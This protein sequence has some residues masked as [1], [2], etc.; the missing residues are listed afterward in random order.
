M[1]I[2]RREVGAGH[3]VYV[4]AEVGV[5]HDG[6]VGRAL[7][8]VDVA[9]EAGADAVKVQYFETDRLMS[10]EAK[11]AAY[12]RAAGETDPVSMLRRLELPIDALGAIAERAWS[13]GL[14]AIVTVFS[15]E[16][17]E[18]AMRV[19]WDAYKSASP[20]IVNKPLLEAMARVG[21]P[22]IVS[23]GASTIDEVSRARGWLSGASERLAFLQCVSSYPA[24]D[25]ALGGISAVGRATGAVVGYSDHTPG[26]ETG[27]QA[28]RAGACLLE[29]HLTYDTRAAGPDHAASLDARG[30]HA[31]VRLAKAEATRAAPGGSAGRTP[32]VGGKVVSDAEHDVRRVSRQSVVA[33]RDLPAGHVLERG[34]LTIKRPGTGLEPW[35]LDEVVGR[36]LARSIAADRPLSSDD[37][38]EET[39]RSVA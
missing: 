16:L 11:L 17:V 3:P 33:T 4:I 24:I 21:R 9:G 28:V 34:D 10:S 32:E 37:V 1:R 29:K 20:D 7:E 19:R 14:E 39:A 8:L 18:E 36:A 25:P 22:L 15:V 35:R 6:S 38:S 2:G 31:Y 27:A 5:N 12:Q 13:R 26:V 23:T 30:M